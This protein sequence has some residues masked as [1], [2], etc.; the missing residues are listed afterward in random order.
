MTR[1]QVKRKQAGGRRGES[2]Q[3]AKQSKGLLG[4]SAGAVRPSESAGDWTAAQ[5]DLVQ[6]WNAARLSDNAEVVRMCDMLL[7]DQAKSEAARLQRLV[8]LAAVAQ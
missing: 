3:P 7:A 6:T 1:T 8:E 2:R 5:D 4:R